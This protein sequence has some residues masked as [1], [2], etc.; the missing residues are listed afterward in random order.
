M[1]FAVIYTTDNG[2]HLGQHRVPGG[3]GLP[4]LS[5]VNLPFAVRGPGIRRRKVSAIPQSHVDIAPTLLDIAGVPQDEWPE[6]FDGRSLLP[7]WQSED[8]EEAL[9]SKTAVHRE[10]I[11]VEFWGSSNAP[12][13]QWSQRYQENTYK[14]LRLIAQGEKNGWLF[15][16]WC[17]SN[18][19][20]LYDTVSDP[21]E[22]HNLAINPDEST[23]RLMARLSGLLLVTKSCSQETCR[24]PWSVLTEAYS[25]SVLDGL[26]PASQ[27]PLRSSP[28]DSLEEAMHPA[29]DDFFAQLPA[30]G[31]Q[32][33]PL[34]QLT[35]NEG[36]YFPAESEDLG[37]RFRR[38]LTGE[39]DRAEEIYYSTNGTL[40][41]ESQSEEYFG[42]MSQR[43]AKATDLYASARELSEEEMGWETE[44]EGCEPDSLAWELYEDD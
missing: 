27:I 42:D 4:Y 33:C 15:N 28:F 35:S 22:L 1:P 36:P 8:D 44:I 34:A 21:Y 31:F 3:K 23:R 43:Y 26:R 12:A 6:F 20:E 19:T 11:N 25:K 41:I 10:V 13:S 16:R 38:R 9:L 18:F 14:S 40:A 39:E 37:R 5:D 17:M 7:E 24:Q 30:P 29:Y 2:F 32:F